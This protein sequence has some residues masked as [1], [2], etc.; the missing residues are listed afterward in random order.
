MQCASAI[1]RAHTM[2]M[3]SLATPRLPSRAS[4]GRVLGCAQATPRALPSHSQPTP[5]PSLTEQGIDVGGM[6]R[7]SVVAAVA[8]SIVATPRAAHAEERV[9]KPRRHHRRMGETIADDWASQAVEV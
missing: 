9:W 3:Q 6:A 1:M 8:L 5:N 7:V 4:M 2:T